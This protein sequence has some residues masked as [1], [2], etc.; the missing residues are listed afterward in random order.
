MTTENINKIRAFEN[1]E[2]LDS[3]EYLFKNLDE[4][5]LTHL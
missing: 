4:E 1:Q 2:W 3:F 5:R